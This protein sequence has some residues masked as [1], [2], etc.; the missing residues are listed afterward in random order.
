MKEHKDYESHDF[1]SLTEGSRI[2]IEHT[3]YGDP[4]ISGLISKPLIELLD[5][6]AGSV[7]AEKAAYENVRQAARDW[8]KQAALTQQFNRAI[9]YVQIPKAEHS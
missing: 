8:E 2:K 4:D 6:H 1:D 9:E 7:M 3:V 5:L